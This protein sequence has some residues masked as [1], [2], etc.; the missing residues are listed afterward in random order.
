M[1]KK[2]FMAAITIPLI[3][4]SFLAGILFVEAAKANFVPTAYSNNLASNQQ[5]VHFKNGLSD[6]KIFLLHFVVVMVQSQSLKANLLHS[7]CLGVYPWK[8]Q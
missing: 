2:S 6:C 7:L 5:N 8:N 3:L 1:S 4:V